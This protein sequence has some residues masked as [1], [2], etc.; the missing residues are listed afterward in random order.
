MLPVSSALKP[1][2]YN[3]DIQPDEGES[4]GTD[5]ANTAAVYYRGEGYSTTGKRLLGRQ[6][7]GEG[8]LKGLMQY[9]TADA[10]Y[11]YTES[12][13]EFDDFAQF[14]QT[15]LA[16]PKPQHWLSPDRPAL[17]ARAGTLYKPDSILAP[18]AWQRRFR[19]QRAYSLCG[20][21][22]TIASKGVMQA[23]GDLAIAPLQP[24]D[25]L[26]CTSNAVK[27]AVDRILATWIEYLGQR[28]GSAATPVL[29][30]LPVIPL[31]VD[32]DRFVWGESA[33]APRQ[34]LRQQLGIADDDVVVLFVGRL[35]FYGKA[36]PTPMYL[37]L[38]RAAQRAGDRKVHLIQAGWFEDDREPA[39]FER[40]AQLLCP[41]VN[42]IFLDGRQPEVRSD[43]W[44]ASDIFISLSDNIQETFG[45]TPIEAMASGLP[46]VVS[47]WDG[48]R[49]SVRH[50]VDGFHIPTITPPPGA[51]LDL[52]AD[53]Q[54]DTLNYS[55]YMGHAAMVSV[56]DV[57]ACA[58]ALATLINRPELRQKLGE[59]GRQR[60]QSVYHWKHVI[61]AYEE[62]WA[63]LA[64]RRLEAA[65]TAP[66]RVPQTP[67]P[68]CDDPFRLFAHYPT[69]VLRPDTRLR[70]GAMAAADTLPQVRSLWMNQ[71]GES[72][73]I[74]SEM[75]DEVL[76]AIAAAD[77]LTVADIL[78]RHADVPPE[79]VVRALGHALKFDI[80]RAIA[81]PTE[82]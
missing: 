36:H 37:A 67:A 35:I 52:A 15:W 44:A 81:H 60:A 54:A 13:A 29:P 76:R 17:L 8:F 47:A 73:R 51:G 31:G 48:Y 27:T 50:E 61:R 64:E 34:R 57:E 19:N 30:H 2:P 7:A 40:G 21:T 46:V 28:F 25:A 59:N 4:V 9:G 16:R 41:S 66:C 32:C 72:R 75:M 23:I 39:E 65:M 11:C 79:R 49:E 42:A 38:E 55:T 26:I 45:L 77:S 18:L 6:A 62:L 33:R 12:Q 22:H 1:T 70:L 53:F 24:W 3:D 43:V 20:V 82:R 14:A 56:V 63:E 71:F 5:G 68:L 80:L 69:D 10:L 78:A 74:S 58:S